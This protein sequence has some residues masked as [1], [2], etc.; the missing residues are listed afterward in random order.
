MGDAEPDPRRTAGNAA[1]QAVCGASAASARRSGAG[2]PARGSGMVGRLVPAA[3]DGAPPP[4]ARPAKSTVI[5]TVR[6]VGDL[7]GTSGFGTSG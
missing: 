2:S 7:F 4:A 5:R 3:D 1:D 6:G